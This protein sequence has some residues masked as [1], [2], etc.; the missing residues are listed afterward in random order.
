MEQPWGNTGMGLQAVCNAGIYSK[1]TGSD[2][3]DLSCFMHRQLG[4]LTNHKC[5]HSQ[6]KCSTSDSEGF[7]YIIGYADTL[8]KDNVVNLDA[9]MLF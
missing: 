6:Y 5:S 4:F 9:H 3:A 8:C 1:L 7:S 2:T